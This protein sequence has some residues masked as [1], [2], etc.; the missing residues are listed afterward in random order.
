MVFRKS[1]IPAAESSK[2]A[3][4]AL[5]LLSFLIATFGA[6]NDFSLE[7]SFSE[8]PFSV[9]STNESTASGPDSWAPALWAESLFALTSGASVIFASWHGTLL[10]LEGFEGPALIGAAE[11]W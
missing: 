10:V 6:D 1:S 11:W 9:M 4:L 7:W 5:L 2:E 3:D 8:I